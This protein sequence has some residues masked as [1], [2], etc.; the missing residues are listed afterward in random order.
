M[1]R[2]WPLLLLFLHLVVAC[3]SGGAPGKGKLD[4]N[5]IRKVERGVLV[6]EVSE[7]GKI[8]PRFDVDIKSKV[9][10]EVGEVLV[11][12]G[13]SVHAG[14][15]LYTIVDTEYGRNVSLARIALKKAQLDEQN[16]EVERKRKEQ[17]LA[18]RGVSEAEYDMARR[19]VELAKIAVQSARV[20]L[21]AATDQLDYCHITAPIDGVIIRRNVEQGEVV[22]AGVTATLNGDPQLTIA[23]MDKL[24]LEIDLN[25][26][27]VAKVHVGQQARILLD[28]YPGEE[29][30]GTVTRIAASGHTD[31]TRNI[32]VF[33]VKVEVDPA[34]TAVEVKPGMTAEVRI[35]IGEYPN[36]L[37]LPTESVFEKD[38]KSYVYVIKE[39]EGKKS[40]EKA[41][42]AVGRRSSREVEVTSGV[43]EGQEY[44][45]EAE[46]KDMNVKMD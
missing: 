10:G 12:E 13:Q 45:A 3:S 19:E 25:Q 6:D 14:D 35:R 28:A 36:V 40:K 15:L 26:V 27:D 7:S 17:A 5:L 22:T 29:V 44:Y 46:I 21:D 2:R 43:A 23:Q 33:T 4:E 18:S 34:N 1:N 16:A 24:L 9:S 8:A 42:V 39:E 30:P 32:D 31:T 20:Q 11:D 41:E 37:K 38:G